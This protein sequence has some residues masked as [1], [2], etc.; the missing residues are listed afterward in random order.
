[1]RSKDRGHCKKSRITCLYRSKQINF[2]ILDTEKDQNR[3]KNFGEHPE[4][5]SEALPIDLAN[6]VPLDDNSDLENQLLYL[7]IMFSKV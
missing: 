3:K 5:I 4:R 7:K 1:M 6:R 2:Y